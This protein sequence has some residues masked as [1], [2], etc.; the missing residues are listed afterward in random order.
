V[1]SLKKIIFVS[2]G[3]TGV[4]AGV[5][6]AIVYTVSSYH[7][8]LSEEVQVGSVEIPTDD[9]SVESGKRRLHVAKCAECHDADFGGR[10]IIEHAL[11]GRLSGSNLT[12]GEGGIGGGYSDADWVRALRFGRDPDG[13][14]LLG[15]PTT[16][17]QYFSD[18]EIGEMV[19]ALKV[20]DPVDRVVPEQ[21]IGP[22]FRVLHLAGEIELVAAAEID[23]VAERAPS[24]Q[25]ALSVEY[26]QHLARTGGCYSC[27]GPK[28]AGGVM[29]GAPPH[30]PPASNIT[31]DDETGLGDWTEDDFVAAIT[32]GKRP[33]GSEIDPAMPWK[34]NQQMTQLELGALWRFISSVEAQ[35]YGMK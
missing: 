32:R 24:V 27:H 22:L 20:L 35:P 28:L 29:A 14:P 26:G 7:F 18:L 4:L 17:H 34:Y 2:L 33:D 23:V 8:S 3:M 5:L 15:M 19:A 6:I 21:T 13:L 12:Q 31:P 30:M 10:T 11:L 9:E 1:W 25:P 16:D